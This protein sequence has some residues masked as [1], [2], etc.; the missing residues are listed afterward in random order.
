MAFVIVFLL[1]PF[2]SNVKHN[3]FHS[4]IQTSHGFESI[5]SLSDIKE[6]TSNLFTSDGIKKV[7][8]EKQNKSSALSFKKHTILASANNEKHEP[9]KKL[10]PGGH[11]IGVQLHTLG[12]IVV[13]HHLVENLSPGEDAEIKVG[14]IILE[15]NGTKIKKLEDVKKIVQAVG[16]NNEKIDVKLKRGKKIME[17]S[18]KVIY[19]QD[20]HQYQIGL[21]IRDATSGIGTVSFIDEG[22]G[23]YGALGHIISDNDTKKP[24]EIY[25]GKL[26]KSNITSIEKGNEG[27]PGEKKADFSI[28][29]TK[30]GNVKKNSPFGIF[31]ELKKDLLENDLQDPISIGLSHEVEKGPAHILTVVE[32]EKIEKFDIEIINSTP[33]KSATTKGMVIKI[34]DERLLNKTGGIVQGMS[35]SPIIQNDK[36]IGAVTHVFVNDPTSGYGVH[37]EWMLEEADIDIFDRTASQTL[38]NV[39]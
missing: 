25:K 7:N 32:G 20:D 29:D 17:T 35:G 28:H 18:L 22:T 11:S 37:I 27:V 6:Y 39:I 8:S 16:K 5:L 38:Q 2:N 30:L 36:I 12:V 14:D 10:I 13:G 33:Q 21:Y 34:T 9:N 19:N 4:T 1:F 3:L 15:M 26:V 24:L 23:K 31:G